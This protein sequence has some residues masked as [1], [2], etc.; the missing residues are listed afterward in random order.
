MLKG[1]QTG[2]MH[3][4]H[5]WVFRAETY[6]TMLAWY[7][8]IRALTEKTG[9]ERTA[10]V[11]SHARSISAGSHKSIES[12]DGGM[13][14][15]EADN[16]PYSAQASLRHNSEVE[17]PK[18]QRPSPGGRF[19]SDLNANR[20]LR[21]PLSPSSGTS[22]PDQDLIDNDLSTAAGGLGA[23]AILG[24]TAAQHRQQPYQQ[25][26]PIQREL[27]QPH[28]APHQ[29]AVF[30]GATTAQ[31]EPLYSQRYSNNAGYDAPATAAYPQQPASAAA[32][33]PAPYSQQ[34][35]P[36]A[37]VQAQPNVAQARSPQFQEDQP[38]IAR[39]NSTYG[40]WMTPAA[41]GAVVGAAGG[42]LGADAYRRHHDAAEQ[43]KQQQAQQVPQE[44]PTESGVPERHPEH[45]ISREPEGLASVSEPS[46]MTSSTA[47]TSYSSHNPTQQ[48]KEPFLGEREAAVPTVIPGTAPHHTTESNAPLPQPATTGPAT[49][50]GVSNAPAP[51]SA[52][53]AGQ[54]FEKEHYRVGK[55]D[56]QPT[57][58]IFPSVIRHNTNMSVSDLPVPGQYPKTPGL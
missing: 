52:G 38:G 41:G 12:S 7:E 17:A 55:E 57:G 32:P 35:A 14:E 45:T 24:S 54:Y 9:A 2:G 31:E 28:D 10:F 3:R 5:S 23:G 36:A 16:V 49:T 43:L 25:Q 37:P 27:E 19:P 42:A 53:P 22:E 39:H 44:M 34:P 48:S 6:D 20:H 1:R 51:V 26:Q 18:P 46:D 8:D 29:P 15:D 21:E 50:A 30:G 33:V 56:A 11:R 58:H 47:P 13:E 40:D 4:G